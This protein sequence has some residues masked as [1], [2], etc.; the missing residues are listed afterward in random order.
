MASKV[1]LTETQVNIILKEKSI[2]IDKVRFKFD[3]A[4]IN[5]IKQ[6]LK[7]NKYYK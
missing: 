4:A 6:F 1:T 7:K 5:K 2:V 3:L